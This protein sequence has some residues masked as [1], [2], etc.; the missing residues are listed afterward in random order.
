MALTFFY[1]LGSVLVIALGT[2]LLSSGVIGKLARSTFYLQ[3]SQLELKRMLAGVVCALL[4]YVSFLMHCVA[5][6]LQG[7]GGVWS[8]A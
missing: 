7:V 2:V 8:E 5:R 6:L 4:L 1:T 3:S